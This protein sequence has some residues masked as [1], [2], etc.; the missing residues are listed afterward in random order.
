[1]S[2]VRS[3]AEELLLAEQCDAQGAHD[4]AINALARATKLGDVEATTRLAKRL[5]IG[6]RAPLCPPRA[7]AF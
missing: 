7:P 2:S 4:D 1:M 5:I 6:N 3:A